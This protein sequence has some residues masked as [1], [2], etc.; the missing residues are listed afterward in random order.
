M[1]L[2]TFDGTSNVKGFFAL[3]ELI[4]NSLLKGR[5]DKDELQKQYLVGRLEDSPL[6]WL[7]G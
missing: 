5:V 6:A 7:M 4:S 3:F 1:K 2:P